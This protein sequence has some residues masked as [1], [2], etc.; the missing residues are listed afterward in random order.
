MYGEVHPD[1]AAALSN[2]GKIQMKLG[3]LEEAQKSFENSLAITQKLYGEVHPNI[4]A[5]LS[6]LGKIQMKAC[7]SLEEAQKSFKNDLAITQKLLR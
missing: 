5:A 7:V 4:A 2:L 6:N 3:D 1:I